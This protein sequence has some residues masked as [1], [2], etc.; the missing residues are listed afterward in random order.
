MK[1]KNNLFP[2]AYKLIKKNEELK[3]GE[4]VNLGGVWLEVN[5]NVFSP[6]CSKASHFYSQKLKTFISF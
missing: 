3:E 1:H 5:P 6:H 2:Q 4:E